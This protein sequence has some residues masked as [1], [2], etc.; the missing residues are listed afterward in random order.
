M[1]RR[2]IG[3]YS[4]VELIGSNDKERRIQKSLD[5]STTQNFDE[6][7]LVEAIR[8]I[9]E[10]HNIPIQVDGRALEEIGLSEEE[11]ITIS[12]EDV[13]L[14]SFLRLMLREIDLTYMIQDEVMQITTIE[15][16]EQNLINKVYPV[17]DLVIPITSGGGGQ[18]G[19]RG[20]GGGQ[21]GG[22]GGG[23]GGFGG[24]GG[25]GGGGQFAVPDETSITSKKSEKISATG[26]AKS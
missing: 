22:Q 20:G 16:A 21:G 4:S 15:K 1:S 17:G 10:T 5:E 18:G 25:G 6:T 14:R 3:R 13:S 11:P 12:L 19:G 26:E 7:P 2:R 8:E 23:G 9:R 24:G